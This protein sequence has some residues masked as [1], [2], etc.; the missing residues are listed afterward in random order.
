VIVSK[1]A[2]ISIVKISTLMILCVVCISIYPWLNQQNISSFIARH[3]TGAPL[4]FIIICA[5]RPL[6]FFLPSM[7][8]TIVAGTLF[9]AWWGTI[10]VAIGGALSTLVGFYFARWLGRDWVQ[11]LIRSNQPMRH[12]DAWFRQ[13]GKNSILFMR[14]CNLP[15]DIVSYW[16][17]LTGI[18]FR[19]F[20]L[21]S[22]MAL[23][24]FSFLYT[25]F[26]TQIF[27]PGTP[28]FII[29]LAIIIVMGSLPYIIISTKK[30]T[31][32]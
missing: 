16:A 26:G 1:T 32:G 8:L 7:G 18:A 24:P 21:A 11:T 23:L 27:T 3:S 19:D 13:H 12:L 5:L 22:L 25:Y 15:W 6:L 29:S 20:Y 9:G 31:N 17:G 4:V 10:Y 14:F 30:S 28:G 2:V